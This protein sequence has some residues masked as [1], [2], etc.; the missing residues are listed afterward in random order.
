MDAGVLLALMMIAGRVS[1][2]AIN[3]T[4]CDSHD[5]PLHHVCASA[6]LLHPVC[7]SAYL[8]H[9]V[10]V[11]VLTSYTTCVCLPFYTVCVC[12]CLP[13]YILRVCLPPTPCVCSCPPASCMCACR[14]SYSIMSY[15]ARHNTLLNG[16]RL[17]YSRVIARGITP[18]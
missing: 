4:C 3:T 15:S 1:N 13:S 9:P 6:Y 5:G 18:T 16:T 12:V 7:A 2:A 17:L 11:R 8:L 10:C 14:P